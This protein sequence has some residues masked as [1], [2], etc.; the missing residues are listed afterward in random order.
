MIY[1]GVSSGT[2]DHLKCVVL[3]YTLGRR[4]FERSKR[5]CPEF[6]ITKDK[7]AQGNKMLPSFK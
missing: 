1:I 7:N 6:K 2:L 5:D 4:E 3:C